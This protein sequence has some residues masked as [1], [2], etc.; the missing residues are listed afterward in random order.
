[1]NQYLV[2]LVQSFLN[3]YNLTITRPSLPKGHEINLLKLLVDYLPVKG[4]DFFVVQIGA[5]DGISNDPIYPLIK[6]R[7][8][9]GVLLEPIPS[10]FKKLSQTYSQIPNVKL[11]NC[12]IANQDGQ[13][14]MYRVKEDNILSK[15]KYVPLQ[16]LASSDR[17]VLLK[18]LKDLKKRKRVV[19]NIAE[20]IETIDVPA[21]TI[22]SLLFSY[23]IKQINLLQVDTEGFDYEIIK[24]IFESGVMPD[25]INFE[26][27]HLSPKDKNECGFLLASK[28]YA[29]L[30]IHRDT[31]AIKTCLIN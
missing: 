5:N 16:E 19:P 2:N 24:M 7:G 28:G 20:F 27:C 21:K 12:A 25:I 6:D 17:N 14:T 8:W 30:T 31:I 4:Q 22:K 29:Y 13:I 15:S 18:T 23:N 1:M 11:E 10:A 9:S 3:K 26:S